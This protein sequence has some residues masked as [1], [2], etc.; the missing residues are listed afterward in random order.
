LYALEYVSSSDSV[1]KE[2]KQT[3]SGIKETLITKLNELCGYESSGSVNE[4]GR[5][6]QSTAA[7]WRDFV[8]PLYREID[9]WIISINQEIEKA[10]ELDD[11]KDKSQ[12]LIELQTLQ[13]TLTKLKSVLK[14]AETKVGSMLTSYTVCFQQ[15]SEK[16]IDRSMLGRIESLASPYLQ[17]RKKCPEF[18]Q[19]VINE[20]TCHLS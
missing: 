7:G 19:S 3:I 15:C 20:D 8:I 9:K 5:N 12:K 11:T 18:I 13:S 17:Y 2:F 16:T 4:A 14:Q 10:S 6:E 1:Q